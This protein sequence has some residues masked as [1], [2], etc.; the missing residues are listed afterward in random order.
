MIFEHKDNS[1]Y[2]ILLRQPK[3]VHM[4]K[5]IRK[6]RKWWE[7]ISCYRYR[8]WSDIF[9]KLEKYY[10]CSVY[11][12]S[13]I[14]EVTLSSGKNIFPNIYY[15]II[16][17]HKTLEVIYISQALPLFKSLSQDFQK[18]VYFSLKSFPHNTRIQE[19]H[20]YLNVR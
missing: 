6:W 5:L 10:M 9:F 8:Y 18:Y 3:E 17:M 4:G 7:L 20:C 2:I 14:W 12:T 19:Q 11:A 15:I 1:S 13:A 16:L